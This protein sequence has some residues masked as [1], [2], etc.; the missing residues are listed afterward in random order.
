KKSSRQLNTFRL[1]IL[2]LIGII[3]LLGAVSIWI[4]DFGNISDIFGNSEDETKILTSGVLML[5][6]KYVPHRR[7]LRP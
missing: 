1:E 2:I 6:S 7:A 4:Q 5:R 3:V